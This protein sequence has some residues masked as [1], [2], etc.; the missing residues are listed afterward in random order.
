MGRYFGVANQIVCTTISLGLAANRQ[1][2]RNRQAAALRGWS[3]GYQ[4][5]KSKR[6]KGFSGAVYDDCKLCP[7]PATPF[8]LTVPA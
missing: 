7:S 5:E 4:V 1:L 3:N 6:L 2:I 8:K